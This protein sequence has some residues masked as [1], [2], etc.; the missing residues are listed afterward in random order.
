VRVAGLPPR[1]WMANNGSFRPPDAPGTEMLSP[2]LV[3]ETERLVLRHLTPDDLDALA[4]IQADPEVMRHFPS[5]PRDRDETRR[6]LERC[7]ALQARHGFSLWAAVDRAEGRLI[8]RC[9]LLPQKLQGAD[10]VEIAY[11]LARD[12]WGQGLATEA[13]LAI[14]DHGF[15]RL[16]LRRLVSIIDRGNLGSRRVAEK[17]GLRQERVIQFMN[18]RCF[19]YAIALGDRDRSRTGAS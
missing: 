5:G 9:G 7:I 12:R 13:A 15:D 16:G 17:A 1:V 18:H 11:L 19:L 14:R 4:E 10:E 2:M 3:I 8:G 6:D